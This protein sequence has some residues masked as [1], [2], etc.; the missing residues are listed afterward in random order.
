[1]NKYEAFFKDD[2]WEQ[3]KEPCYPA[4]RRLYLNDGRFWVSRNDK[5]QILF[6]VHEIGGRSVNGLENLEGVEV[7]I[8]EI[9]NDEYRL[10]CILTVTDAEMREKFS[11]VSK[12]VAHHCSQFKGAQ[13]FIQVQERIKSWANFLKP[14]RCGLSQSEF[15]GLWGELY[16]VSE[17]LMNIHSP[18]DVVR[19]WVGPEGKKQDITLNSIAIEVKASL[20]GDPRS[21]QISSIDQ[22][23]R[24][25][26]KLYLLHLI[27][28]PSNSE[29]G[30]T[31]ETLYQNCLRNLAHDIGAETLF[32]QKTSEL[33]GKANEGQLREK[34]SIV[35]LSLFDVRD[36]FPCITREVINL[37]I[38]SVKY[39]ILV[40]SIKKFDVTDDIEGIIKNG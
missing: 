18:S 13:L 15:V 26:E 39:E 33:Y 23:D 24:I 3:I 25:T 30:I 4:G 22:L 7:R 20:S 9:K 32:L 31:L 1:M 8:E 36:D 2:P 14:N 21:I 28:N 6:F 11:I 40:S 16:V 5:D 37:G 29:L 27:A 17:L 10:C 34:L 19:F 35:S 12:D 38:A